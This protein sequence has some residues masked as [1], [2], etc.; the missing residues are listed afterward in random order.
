MEE[1]QIT[2]SFLGT[3]W[4]FPPSFSTDTF[5]IQMVSAEE[6]I[7]QSL[8][9]LLSTTPGERIMNP[10]YG[11]DMQKF[12]FSPLSTSTQTEIS[13]IVKRAIL[14]Y[15]PRVHVQEVTVHV[16][17]IDPGLL[18]IIIDYI[19]IQTNSRSNMVYPFYHQEGTNII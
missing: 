4:G 15:E 18:H 12:I 10:A 11:C 17:S 6:D 9:L 16:V 14:L 3:G 8:F 2:K 7:K 5:A 13:A 1:D 19:V